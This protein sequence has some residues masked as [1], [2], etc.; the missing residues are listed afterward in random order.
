MLH[1][2]FSNFFFSLG[3]GKFSLSIYNKPKT[4]LSY[5]RREVSVIYKKHGTS[6]GQVKKDF[7][8]CNWILSWIFARGHIFHRIFDHQCR[9]FF[10]GFTENLRRHVGQKLQKC[11]HKLTTPDVRWRH[12]SRSKTSWNK[13][14][15]QRRRDC[16]QIES[17]RESHGMRQKDENFKKFYPKNEIQ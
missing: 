4:M 7:L 5:L 6:S 17:R 8:W 2:T 15:G 1:I 3:S 10:P 9:N 11:R 12:D 13:G 16:T 14:F